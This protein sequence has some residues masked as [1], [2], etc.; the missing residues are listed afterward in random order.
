MES[1]KISYF[2]A[3]KKNQL[4]DR[5][6]MVITLVLSQA[7]LMIVAEFNTSPFFYK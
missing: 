3:L 1:E 6:P 4:K 5:K 2:T 7:F